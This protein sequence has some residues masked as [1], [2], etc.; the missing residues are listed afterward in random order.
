MTTSSSEK[1]AGVKTALSR[2]ANDSADR[3]GWMS[4]LSNLCNFSRS[5][6][7]LLNGSSLL[8]LLS[9]YLMLTLKK[10]KNYNKK[11]IIV[12]IINCNI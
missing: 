10:V 2:L 12:Y 5:S 6:S 3:F 9:L 7:K 1:E 8:L 4:S 11:E